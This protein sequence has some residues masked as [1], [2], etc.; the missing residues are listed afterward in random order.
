MNLPYYLKVTDSVKYADSKM[1]RIRINPDY[2]KHEGLMA[3]E[4]EHIKQWYSFLAPFLIVA[5]VC[6]FTY[7]EQIAIGLFFFSLMAKDLTYTLIKPA[8]VWLEARAYR[9]QYKA[10]GEDSLPHL[11]KAFSDVY[12]V[13]Y[14]KAVKLIA[15]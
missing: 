14:E 13:E 6:W 4:E 2:E 1:C 15:G 10:M 12:D 11:A 3:H 8:R 5:I 7:S 9:A